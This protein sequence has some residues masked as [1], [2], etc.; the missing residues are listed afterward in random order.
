MPASGPASKQPLLGQR[1]LI[2]DDDA[3]IRRMVG[4]VLETAG[5]S[6]EHAATAADALRSVQ[7][8]ADLAAIVLDWN[9]FDLS[10]DAFLARLRE[11]RPE[12]L[13][14][15]AVITGDLVRRG[16]THPAEQ[17]GLALV[18]KPFRPSVLVEAVATL[19]DRAQR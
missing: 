19:I 3:D 10:A 11:T 5:A 15:V 12:L 4:K 2:V 1:I 14:R 8:A 16:A 18:H 7:Q 6:V 17:L 9:L 13:R